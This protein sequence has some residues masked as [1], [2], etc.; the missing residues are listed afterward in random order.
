LI[1]IK[2]IKP[3]LKKKRKPKPVQINQFRF[4]FLE[5]KPVQTGLTRFFSVWLG[6][7]DLAWFFRFGSVCFP[8]FSV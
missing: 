3:E 4:G 7:F 5:Q 8:V 2:K 1:F 6:F